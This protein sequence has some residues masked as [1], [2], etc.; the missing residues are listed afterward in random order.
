[1][2]IELLHITPEMAEQMLEKNT[3]NR[4]LK[5]PTVLRY[6][7]E[8][9]LGRWQM[10]HQGVAISDDGTV[11]DGQHRLAA[12]VESG[13]TVP[14][15]LTSGLGMNVQLLV[16]DH[17]KRTPHDALSVHEATRGATS[18]FCAIATCM[19]REGKNTFYLDTAGSKVSL[20]EFAVKHS[21]AIWFAEKE[22]TA[23]GKRKGI[24]QASI[25]GVIARASYTHS[26]SR[27][28][29]FVSVLYSG[30]M[31]SPDDVAAV[32]LRN[33][34][35]TTDSGGGQAKRAAYLKTERCLLA[36]CEYYQLRR[37]TSAN[38]EL[39]PIPGD[40]A[41]DERNRLNWDIAW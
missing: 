12:I 5:R 31:A 39:F 17:S 36:F 37:C 15:M 21:Q 18:E 35:L 41:W 33:Y 26:L 9:K 29:S 23:R 40:D 16:D 2:K 32:T 1:M 19:I 24:S 10:T 34:L 28:R 22:Q 4:K 30:E 7:R 3:H 13:R 20:L 6:A 38:A 11:I 8:M 14:M 27:I 25:F